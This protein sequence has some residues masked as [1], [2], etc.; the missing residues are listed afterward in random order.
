ME[1]S[2]LSEPELRLYL[3][4]KGRIEGVSACNRAH[5]DETHGSSHYTVHRD[6]GCVRI[7]AVHGY[8][9]AASAVSRAMSKEGALA[10]LEK[11]RQG[12]EASLDQH[13]EGDEIVGQL[14]E[15]L[16]LTNAEIAETSRSL[17]LDRLVPAHREEN[18]YIRL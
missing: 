17:A 9:E 2:E 6:D 16:A 5:R 18:K 3:L 7:V 4:E 8:Q 13:E 1:A 15:R 12:I 11:T 14:K 10:D